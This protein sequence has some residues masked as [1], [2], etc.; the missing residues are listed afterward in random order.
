M[1]QLSNHHHYLLPEHFYLPK[2]TA[3]PIT[4]SP[5]LLATTDLFV[6][7]NLPI[8]DILYKWNDTICGFYVWLLSLSILFS[9]FIHSLACI[10]SLSLIMAELWSIVWN[11]ILHLPIHRLIGIWVVS[12]LGLLWT[13]LLWTFLYKCLCGHIFSFLRYIP[14]S[15]IVGSYATLY[16]TIWRTAR[17]FS[18]ADVLFYINTYSVFHFSYN[19]ANTCYCLFDCRNSSMLRYCSVVLICISLMANDIEHLFMF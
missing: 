19:L 11:I 3:Y 6:S 17:L 5:Q 2:E 15:A 10:S 13:M 4:P 16:S 8:A 18:R 7:M 12:T 14:R 1:S 9:R